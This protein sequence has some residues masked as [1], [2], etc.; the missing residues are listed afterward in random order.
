MRRFI[1]I[2]VATIAIGCLVLAA[3]QGW[4]SV[5]NNRYVV[6]LEQGGYFAIG[7]GVGVAGW[8]VSGHQAM[9]CLFGKMPKAWRLWQKRILA[10]SLP[11]FKYLAAGILFSGLGAVLG[12]YAWEL[13]RPAFDAGL[14]VGAIFG[15]VYS[16]RTVYESAGDQ[17]DFL[18]ANQRYINESKA[19]YFSDKL[20]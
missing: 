15:F 8:L 2:L 3:T 6:R 5:E 19:P 16:S 10:N 12:Y 17:I 4:I 9:S 18:E 20:N 7:W 14:L 1:L 13:F 11:M